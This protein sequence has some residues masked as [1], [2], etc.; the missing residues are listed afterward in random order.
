M[1]IFFFNFTGLLW[2]SSELVMSVKVNR[3]GRWQLKWFDCL[4]LYRKRTQGKIVNWRR[5]QFFFFILLC[6]KWFC[7]WTPKCGFSSDLL[8]VMFSDSPESLLGVWH[9]IS[10]GQLPSC[11]WLGHMKAQTIP[12]SEQKRTNSISRSVP[13]GMQG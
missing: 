3:N 11:S 8:Y 5:K 9:D 4:Q 10:L 13:A 6:F 1:I 2:G 7:F 12:V